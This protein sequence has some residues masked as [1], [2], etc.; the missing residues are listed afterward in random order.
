MWLEICCAITGNPTLI[1]VGTGRGPSPVDRSP[2]RARA[3]EI[4]PGIRQDSNV[5][6]RKTVVAPDHWEFCQA[7]Q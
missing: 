3:T 1:A 2:R 5:K 4:M 7:S 6:P